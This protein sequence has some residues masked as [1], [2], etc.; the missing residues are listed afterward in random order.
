MTSAILAVGALAF[1]IAALAGTAKQYV[2]KHPTREHCKAHYTRKVETVK[3]RE[4]HKTVKV[5]ETFCVYVAPKPTPTPTLAPPTPTPTPTPL[6]AFPA[7]P[8]ASLI[9]TAITINAFQGTLLTTTYID[10][11]ANL[12]GGTLKLSAPV[13]FT[14]T[15]TTT[16]Q[17]VGSFVE[18]SNSTCTVVVTSTAS[19]QTFTGEAVV[20]FAGCA[21]TSVSAPLADTVTLAVSFAGNSNYA[22]SASEAT[23]I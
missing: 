14:M 12:F 23:G 1:P 6:P 5:K 3:V 9:P 16:G 21:L 17:A 22:P 11:T 7:P 19:D 4:H 8:V 2:L 20:P 15:D 18:T 13:T 10:V